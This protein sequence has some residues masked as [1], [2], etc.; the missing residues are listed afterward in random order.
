MQGLGDPDFQN[1]F[2]EEEPLRF[3]LN[4]AWLGSRD[5]GLT[6]FFHTHY[7]QGLGFLL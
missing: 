3:G 2:S 6:S 7:P 5:K 1:D 4:L